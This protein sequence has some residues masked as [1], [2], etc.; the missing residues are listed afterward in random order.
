MTP[1]FFFRGEEFRLAFKALPT[2]KAFFPDVTFLALS[3][4]LTITQKQDLPKML[5]L[6]NFKIIECSPDKPNIYL[7]KFKKEHAS[8]VEEEYENIVNSLCDKLFVE[9][10]NFPV[11]LIYVPVYYM[12]RAIMYLNNLFKPSNINDA[13][14]SAICSGQDQYVIDRT[15]QE[16]KKEHSLIRLVLT[17][18]ILGMGFDPENVTH[19]VHSC[20]PRNISQYF[21]EV[22][23]AG[24]R[25]QPSVASLYY[26][27]RNI[28]RNL[29]GI[30]EDII[31]YCKN[32]TSCLRNCILSVFGFQK[33]SD[34]VDCKCC[35]ICKRNCN[36]DDCLIANIVITD[37]Y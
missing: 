2:L 14:Y 37:S 23:R 11:T 34:I 17:T 18:S 15:M 16:L 35:C 9:R 7:E 3:G 28:A 1:F 24:R 30:T 8:D 32:D 20:P 33:N 21:Q 12:S 36:C 22:G 10:K 6:N 13:I 19:V 31:H 29:P 26:S 4:T 5:G 27:A 25:G